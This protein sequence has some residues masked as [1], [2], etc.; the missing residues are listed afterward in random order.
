MDF[1]LE[2]DM[3]EYTKHQLCTQ[4]KAVEAPKPFRAAQGAFFCVIMVEIRANGVSSTAFASKHNYHQT[5]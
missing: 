3:K 4:R 2:I 5:E 1:F